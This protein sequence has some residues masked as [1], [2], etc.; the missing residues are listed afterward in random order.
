MGKEDEVMLDGGT[1]SGWDAFSAAGGPKLRSE[2]SAAKADCLDEVV[3]EPEGRWLARD[4][5]DPSVVLVV[6]RLIK[7]SSVSPELE[8]L[9]ALA[10]ASK[11]S[12]MATVSLRES[13]SPSHDV[14]PHVSE[15]QC[16]SASSSEPVSIR[17]G[18]WTGG[19]HAVETVCC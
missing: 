8:L 18:D 6:S 19:R 5:F 10:A 12:N 17:L 7:E 3:E 2:S 9:L 11:S 15:G 14:E 13:V 16:C 1:G 4:E